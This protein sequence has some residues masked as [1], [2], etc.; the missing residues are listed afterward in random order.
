MKT[1]QGCKLVSGARKVHGWTWLCSYSCRVAPII[2]SVI[3]I[4]QYRDILTI[5]VIGIAIVSPYRLRI[6]DVIILD[7]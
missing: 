1:F 7:T 6:N 2:G 4:G 5:S 3:G